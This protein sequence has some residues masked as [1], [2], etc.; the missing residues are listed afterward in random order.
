MDSTVANEEE[1]S[2][3]LLISRDQ[4][5]ITTFCATNS[6]LQ[7]FARPELSITKPGATNLVAPRL[8][9]INGEIFYKDCCEHPE[10]LLAIIHRD[11][12]TFDR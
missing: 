2:T 5:S 10:Y 4:V 1:I 11:G 12:R 9:R 7:N 8:N 6:R 3:L